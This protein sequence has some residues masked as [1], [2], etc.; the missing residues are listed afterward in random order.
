MTPSRTAIL[1][2]AA[3]AAACRPAPETGVVE[4]RAESGEIANAPAADINESLALDLLAGSDNHMAAPIGYGG[5]PPDD[6]ALRFVGRW[7]A[8]EPSCRGQ[9]W[10]FT[11]DGLETPAGSVCRFGDITPVDGGYDI[12]AR[13][14][15]EAPEQADTI[16]LRFAESAHAML[17]ESNVIADTG[18]V[19]CGPNE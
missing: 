12:A 2:L 11:A 18:L 6:R 1:L 17:F 8:E 19:Y 16:R 15:A 7:A 5:L 14:T 13:C 4:N 10:R 9:A 3:L